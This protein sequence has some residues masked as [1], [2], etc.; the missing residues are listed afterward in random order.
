[1]DLF[2]SSQEDLNSQ[3]WILLMNTI[4]YNDSSPI[5]DYYLEDD[6]RATEENSNLLE[7][8]LDKFL[9]KD[10]A[11]KIHLVKRILKAF[12]DVPDIYNL[13]RFFLFYSNFNN[14]DEYGLPSKVDWL[15]EICNSKSGSIEIFRKLNSLYDLDKISHELYVNGLKSFVILYYENCITPYNEDTVESDLYELIMFLVENN[16]LD[17][18]K[19]IEKQ[20]GNGEV[21]VELRRAL[22]RYCMVLIDM[23]AGVE[24][25]DEDDL[26]SKINW[27]EVVESITQ[28]L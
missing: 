6:C 25:P 21:L 9:E 20:H 18:Q 4:G 23:P 15:K 11:D 12:Y 16:S 27:H 1:M 10:E 17:D 3:G 26:Y 7:K 5:D 14:Y 24:D 2:S 19:I 28:T 8:H 13:Y 22:E